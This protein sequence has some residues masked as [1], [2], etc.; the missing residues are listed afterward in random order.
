MRSL[1]FAFFGIC[2][3]VLFMASPLNVFAQ[4]G[5]PAVDPDTVPITG[6]EVLIGLGSLLGVK[7][8][9][10]LRKKKQD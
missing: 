3:C 9:R 1:R 5:D 10:D 8:I 4:P 6:I 7:K 2:I